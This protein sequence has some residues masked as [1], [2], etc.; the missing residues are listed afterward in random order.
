M[1]DRFEVSGEWVNERRDIDDDFYVDLPVPLYWRVMIAPVAPKEETKG[2]IIIPKMNQDA[3]DILN[4][5]GIVVALGSYAGAHERLGG[6]GTS[7]NA[8]FPKVGDTVFY[9][10]HAGA[11]M[12]HKGRKVILLNDDEILALVPNADTIATSV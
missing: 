12:L 4:C 10:R 8:V 1:S 7:A 11:M 6:D 3:Q 5:V 2:G 9:G